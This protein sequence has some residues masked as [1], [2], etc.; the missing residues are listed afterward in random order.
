MMRKAWDQIMMEI[1]MNER[2]DGE[3]G[4]WHGVGGKVLAAGGK[5]KRSQGMG[6]RT[7]ASFIEDDR[8][9]GSKSTAF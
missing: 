8:L 2:H 3:G 6:G 9:P 7:N 5:S 4:Q 1:E